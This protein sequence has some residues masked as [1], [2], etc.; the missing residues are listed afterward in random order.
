MVAALLFVFEHL[1]SSL[2]ISI[3]PSLL[4]SIPK[5]SNGS[6]SMLMLAKYT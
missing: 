5:A 3:S 6:L 2:G 4:G 1:D